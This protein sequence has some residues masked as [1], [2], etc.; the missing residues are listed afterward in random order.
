MRVDLSHVLNEGMTNLIRWR[1]R[2]SPNEYP[3]KVLL[4]LF[5]RKYATESMWD[6][7]NG[8]FKT[9]L[10]GGKK[11]LWENYIDAYNTFRSRHQDVGRSK[12]LPILES[13]LAQ[14]PG[15]MV[16]NISYGEYSQRKSRANNGSSSDIEEI[17]YAYLYYYLADE[18]VML[19]ASIGGTGKDK[20]EAIGLL[21]GA[22]IETPEI[23]TYAHAESILGRL[24]VA[25]YL[26]NNYKPLPPLA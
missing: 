6:E 9:K 21:S 25:P 10:F 20:I 4:N 12:I 17:E 13:R 1:N 14:Q 16:G 7:L 11:V 5:Y 8:A 22:I 19:W 26:H 24:C 18:C 15:R 23:N 2:Y 3:E